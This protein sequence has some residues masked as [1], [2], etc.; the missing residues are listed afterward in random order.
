MTRSKI[1]TTIGARIEGPLL[2]KV[3]RPVLAARHRR[4]VPL[5]IV[6]VAAAAAP[7]SA[8][9][10]PYFYFQ[11]TSG[12][13][14][15]AEAIGDA[16]GSS[17]TLA[18]GWPAGVGLPTA[19]GGWP[20]SAPGFAPDASFGNNPGISGYHTSNLWL[21]DYA[22][23]RFQFMGSGNA[24]YQ[25][26]FY[27]NGSLVYDNKTTT[28]SGSNPTGQY[29]F[30][31]GLVPFT[32]VANV[33]GTGGT[34]TYVIVNGSNTANPVN[35]AAFFLGVDPYTTGTTFETSGTAVYIGLSDRPEN[36]PDHDFQDLSVKVWISA[37]PEPGTFMLAVMGAGAAAIALRRRTRPRS[38]DP[39]P[40]A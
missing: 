1:G 13:T 3:F 14:I 6:L 28:T 33:T 40:P 19:L 29:L 31:P 39:A 36:V 34:A 38:P 15:Q 18:N 20:T 12:T 17:Y 2:A 4:I 30:G 32:Y 16:G 7:R 35:G 25:N 9:S 5:A 24:G 22:Y 37:V 21:S 11:A 23:V 26:Q 10:Q 8:S 27:V